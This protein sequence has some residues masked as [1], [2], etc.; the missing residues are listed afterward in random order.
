MFDAIQ[1]IKL[2]VMVCDG[3]KWKIR[4]SVDRETFEKLRQKIKSPVFE[5]KKYLKIR[6]GK[7]EYVV[8]KE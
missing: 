1:G 3:M 6:R 2:D 7:I 4:Q 8:R 5:S